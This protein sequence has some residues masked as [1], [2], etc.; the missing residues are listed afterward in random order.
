MREAIRIRHYSYST[1]R[2]YLDWVERF[3]D[4]TSNVKKKD[5]QSAGLDPG[6][7]KDFLSYLALKR[8]VSSS[9]QNQAFN[10][11]LFLFRDV[12]KIEPGDL[13]KTV[14]AKRGQKLPVVLS[15]EEVQ[16]LFKHVKGLNLLILQLLYGSGLRLMELARLRVK[17]ID[18][19]QNLIFVRGS[20]GDQDRTT[21]LPQTVKD[22]LEKHL[23]EVKKLHDKDLQ[24]G[25]GEAYLPDALERKYPNAPKEW[26]WQYVF[27]SSKLSVDPRSGKIRRHHLSEK[28][29][30]NTV[31]EAVR[32]AGIVKH[33]SVHTLRHSFATHLLMNGVNIREIQNL[34]GH[35]HVETTMIY[36]HVVRDMVSVPR[37]P[38]DRL[39]D[40]KPL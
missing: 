13:S 29:I 3:I 32:K 20:K 22:M 25:Y 4:Y 28:T 38:L 10:A 19:D 16:S 18:F 24:E 11:I 12:L 1:E 33:A 21:I 23:D 6:D 7:I 9:T 27:P 2:S 36:T 39:Y 31:K 17:D 30:Q 14:R 5:I 37:S 26:G 35:K 34:L 40:K 8:R 15:P